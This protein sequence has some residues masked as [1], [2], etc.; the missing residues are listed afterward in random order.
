MTAD[1]AVALGE[2][3]ARP[4]MPPEL[5]AWARDQ[6][7]LDQAWQECPRADWLLWIAAAPP[8][9]EARQRQLVGAASAALEITT[10][11]RK[12][13][14]KLLHLS[15]W[16]QEVGQLW[17]RGDAPKHVD[18]ASHRWEDAKNGIV[19]T[20]AVVLPATPVVYYALAAHGGLAWLTQPLLGLAALALIPTFQLLCQHLRRR[21]LR[22]ALERFTY[23]SDGEALFTA[24]RADVAGSATGPWRRL[25]AMM[26]RGQMKRP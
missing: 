19:L 23:A 18:V 1:N 15:P 14:R 25:G 12:W 4:D 2:L 3:L 9:T 11:R 21:A 8:A 24:L 7:S 22:R 13:W 16:P 20:A 26:F 17:A 5:A 6:A 10:S